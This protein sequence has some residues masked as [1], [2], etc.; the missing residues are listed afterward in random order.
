M[1]AFVATIRPKG[2]PSVL[3]LFAIWVLVYI[4][5]AIYWV[6]LW[7]KMVRW[8][9]RR[10]LRSVTVTAIAIA[11]GCAVGGFCEAITQGIP[12]QIAVLIGGGVVPI[13]WVLGTVIVW[14]ETPAERA[15]R[16]Q[17]LGRRWFVRYADTTWRGLGRRF[18][19]SAAGRLRWINWRRARGGAARSIREIEEF[20]VQCR[21]SGGDVFVRIAGG[22]YEGISVVGSGAWEDFEEMWRSLDGLAKRMI[23]YAALVGP[24]GVPVAWLEFL[25][26]GKRGMMVRP[27]L[28][29]TDRDANTVEQ[30]VEGGMMRWAEGQS[31]VI[32]LE[33][34]IAAW[35]IRQIDE[36]EG[37]RA[38]Y[39]NEITLLALD[40]GK[41]ARQRP[42]EMSLWNRAELLVGLAKKLAEAGGHWRRW[43]WREGF[44]SHWDLLAG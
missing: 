13:I 22:S 40:R 31:K 43:R 32:D 28:G 35:R 18:A 42:E 21:D 30:L 29:L 16:W 8:T 6:L 14:R 19:R 11:C 38:T 5:V 24:A 37:S 4:F 39:W 1:L 12:G 36:S 10:V 34:E 2:P 26:E 15:E 3:S 17:R 27:M 20:G 9:R 23:D 25:V 41:A 7:N 44:P 33:P